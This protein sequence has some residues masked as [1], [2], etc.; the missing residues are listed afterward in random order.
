[1]D[2]NGHEFL[3][4]KPQMDADERRKSGAGGSCGFCPIESVLNLPEVFQ[5]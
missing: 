5:P 3:F 4:I 1:M 2:T